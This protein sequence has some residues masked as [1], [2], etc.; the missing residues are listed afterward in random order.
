[1]TVLKCVAIRC[2]LFIKSF[3][4]ESQKSLGERYTEENTTSSS[5]GGRFAHAL[6]SLKIPSTLNVAVDVLT[7]IWKPLVTV[8]DQGI[9]DL[10]DVNFV[11]VL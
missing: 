2:K 11:T 4:S 1:M 7:G 3:K 10:V 8:D 9:L 5:K 6:K